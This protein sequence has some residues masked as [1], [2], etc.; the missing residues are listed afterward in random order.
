MTPK[1]SP[2]IYEVFPI[3][4]YLHY[5]FMNKKEYKTLNPILRCQAQTQEE[6]HYMNIC[7]AAENIRKMSR[8]IYI[9]WPI[10]GAIGWKLLNIHCNQFIRES[11]HCLHV[12]PNLNI[13]TSFHCCMNIFPFIYC[14]DRTSIC[15]SEREKREH[16]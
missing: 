5:I 10:D 16:S 9:L 12:S 2:I 13:C 1:Y 6:V 11:L 4:T 15:S 8:I 14:N 7:W 3:K